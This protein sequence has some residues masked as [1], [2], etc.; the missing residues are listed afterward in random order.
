[1]YLTSRAHDDIIFI[2]EAEEEHVFIQILQN[3]LHVVKN[4]T[5]EIYKDFIGLNLEFW[6]AENGGAKTHQAKYPP[7]QNSC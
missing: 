6:L 2:V 4:R 1:M 7:A 3:L 5:H